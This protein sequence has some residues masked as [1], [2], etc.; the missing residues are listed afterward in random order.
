M[1]ELPESKSL[2]KLGRSLFT[3]LEII[4]V[5]A[6]KSEHKFCW[7]NLAKDDMVKH[8]SHKTIV[9]VDSAAHYLRFILN[10]GSMI[11]CA[12]D[13]NIEYKKYDQ[14][15]E[16]HQLMIV[17]KNNYI[18]E[19][20]VKLYAF[21]LYGFHEELI[22]NY[23][24]YKVAYE[25]VDPLSKAFTY[26]YFLEK[27][28]IN[29]GKGSVK[30]ALSTEQHIPGLGNGILQDILF[31]A[32]LNPKRKVI[33][34]SETDKK[35]LYETIITM[36]DKMTFFGGRDTQKNFHGEKGSYQ[37]LMS[38][39]HHQCPV[40]HEILVKEAYLGGKVIYCPKCQL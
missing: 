12:E 19:F 13:I 30:Q 4:D 35:T 6:L 11:V 38:Q 17:F 25:A 26:D 32:K 16:K 27:S 18:L 14:E 31:T 39:E 24:Y 28:L 23:P 33:T 1:I 37:V 8:I 22:N 5:V 2:A 3:G 34:L 10:D 36:I 40:C 15:S 21:I 9:D 29:Q 7:M 20:K